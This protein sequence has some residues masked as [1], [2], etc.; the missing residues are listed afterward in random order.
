MEGKDKTDSDCC[1][2]HDG[3]AAESAAR[4]HFDDLV[5]FCRQDDGTFRSF[6]KSLL[7]RLFAL[8]CLLMRLFLACRHERFV[9][10]DHTP[11]PGYRFTAN[12]LTSLAK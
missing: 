4:Q 9:G 10:Q 7:A 6:E 12:A 2:V 3:A 8:G 11:P 5:R 1:P